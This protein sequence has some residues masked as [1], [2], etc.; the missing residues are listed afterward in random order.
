VSVPLVSVPD[1]S[2]LTHNSTGT[3]QHSCAVHCDLT[4]QRRGFFATSAD[5][6]HTVEIW[7][8]L[9]TD[10][11]TRSCSYVLYRGHR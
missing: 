3:A 4:D 10:T 2:H 8:L 5:F 6:Y 11:S 9:A 7:I 1:P